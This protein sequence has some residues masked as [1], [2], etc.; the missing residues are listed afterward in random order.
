M[1]KIDVLYQ[2]SPLGK[3]TFTFHSF[4]S[5]FLVFFWWSR[6]QWLGSTQEISIY[7]WGSTFYFIAI[8]V[9]WIIGQYRSTFCFFGSKGD[10]F[11]S[12]KSMILVLG[13]CVDL[14]RWKLGYKT[15]RWWHSTT[16]AVAKCCFHIS[17]L[18]SKLLHA[19]WIDTCILCWYRHFPPL[20]VRLPYHR[21]AVGA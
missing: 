19:V 18:L 2:C 4:S 6:S 12:P 11:L 13:W 15:Q 3:V 9:S 8:E 10:L 1:L 7:G 17:K 20:L 14:R 16:G 5:I 21:P